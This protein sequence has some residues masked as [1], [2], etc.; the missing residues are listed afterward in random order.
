MTPALPPPS[1]KPQAKSAPPPPSDQPLA[2]SATPPPSD[3][4]QA[5]SAPPPPPDQPQAKSVTPPP[6]PKNS[7]PAEKQPLANSDKSKKPYQ[8]VGGN[9]GGWHTAI[10]AREDITAATR[11]FKDANHNHPPRW[12]QDAVGRFSRL[13]ERINGFRPVTKWWGESYVDVRE[14]TAE[15]LALYISFLS[16]TQER[17]REAMVIGDEAIHRGDYFCVFISCT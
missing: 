6:P 2:K 14:A 11:W 4:P 7:P 13:W 9:S 17:K 10:M 1:D 16:N 3:K 8:A 15:F 5:K 12:R